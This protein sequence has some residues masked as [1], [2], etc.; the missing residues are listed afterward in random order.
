MKRILS[1]LVAVLLGVSAIN[2]TAW[3]DP[4]NGQTGSTKRA[5]IADIDN[6]KIWVMDLERREISS[7]YAAPA[8]PGSAAFPIGMA[9]LRGRLY[10]NYFNFNFDCVSGNEL[11]ELK[12]STGDIVS[13][14]TIGGCAFDGM[15]AV[16]EAGLV[17]AIDSRKIPEE[18]VFLAP[19]LG[20][21]G[22]VPPNDV[23]LTVVGTMTV[24]VPGEAVRGL[25]YLNGRVYV[26]TEV[27]T[28]EL[29]LVTS[30][31]IYIYQL[32]LANW[33]ITQTEG[34]ISLGGNL[35]AAGL[36]T[37]G[38]N[39]LAYEVE[40]RQLLI[41]EPTVGNAVIVD[42]IPLDAFG[43]GGVGALETRLA[44]DAFDAAQ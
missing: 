21:R 25:A 42:T 37:Y 13:Y 36:A 4:P 44:P 31:R 3:A 30:S 14:W 38:N 12:P 29:Q 43:I 40:N 11:F 39:L 24:D 6:G 41:L 9:I 2:L 1:A 22:R 17:V 34:Y 33:S 15:A 26:S 16:P 19:S 5:W 23:G 7:S 35:A 28:D 8:A 27:V 18:L 32:D 10:V 20:A